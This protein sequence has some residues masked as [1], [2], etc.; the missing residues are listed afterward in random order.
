MRN[1]FELQ[2]YYMENILLVINGSKADRNT[3]DFACYIANL[4]HSKL[5]AVFIENIAGEEQACVEAII[6]AALC[7]NNH[8]K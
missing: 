5:T 7:G 1:I 8:G 4:T 3:V 6:C 2:I